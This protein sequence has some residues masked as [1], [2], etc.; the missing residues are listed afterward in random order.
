ML[1]RCVVLCVGWGD[2]PPAPERCPP[3]S[4]LGHAARV[5]TE[6]APG[7]GGWIP[8]LV[9]GEDTMAPTRQRCR[10]DQLGCPPRVV[11]PTPL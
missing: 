1:C 3:R 6:P 4:W 10:R 8:P 5:L 9:N 2:S 7:V 11:P